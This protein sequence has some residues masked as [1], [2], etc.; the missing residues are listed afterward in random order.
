[1]GRVSRQI[2]EQAS[3][4]AAQ[5]KAMTKRGEMARAV[6]EQDRRSKEY[7]LRVVEDQ[8]KNETWFGFGFGSPVWRYETH[9]MDYP[10]STYFAR[11]S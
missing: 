9:F 4:D 1:M 10:L 6:A 7:A 2:N 8:R 3:A 11:R 5:V